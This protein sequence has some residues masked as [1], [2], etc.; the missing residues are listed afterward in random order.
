MMT[1]FRWPIYFLHFS[2]ST[3]SQKLST[4]ETLVFGLVT[5]L[6]CSLSSCHKFSIGLMSGDSAGVFHQLM[7]FL[8]NY[9]PTLRE[10]CLGSLS[11]MKRISLLSLMKGSKPASKTSINPAPFI[12][13]QKLQYLFF[14]DKRCLPRHELYKGVLL[15]NNNE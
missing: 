1:L 8:S 2:T 9:S 5:R 7:L 10:A 15:C 13:H 11:C 6:I 14:H 3:V 4:P 12:V